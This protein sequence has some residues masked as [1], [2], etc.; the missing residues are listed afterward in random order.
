MMQSRD[1]AKHTVSKYEKKLLGK[2]RRVKSFYSLTNLQVYKLH[3]WG[4]LLPSST[5]PN[6]VIFLKLY[7]NKRFILHAYMYVCTPCTWKTKE[8][9]GSLEPEL[10]QL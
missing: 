5:C 4:L 6:F 3:R 10:E 7:E 9:S 2:F 1:L 8:G